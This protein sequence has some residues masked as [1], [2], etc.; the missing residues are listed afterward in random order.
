M[1][2]LEL[3]TDR[4]RIALVRLS[5][6]G[7]V[8]RVLPV[9]ASLRSR[10][11]EC[12]LT[13][14]VEPGP[15]G[16]LAGHPEVDRFLLFR[17]GLGPAAHAELWWKGRGLEFDLVLDLHRY[18]KAG[19]V[20]GLLDA[21]VKLGFD[22]DR[23]ADL[24]WWFTT[25]RIPPNPRRHVQEEYFEFLD[26]LGVPVVREWPLPVTPGERRRQRAEMEGLG[27]VL[28][29]QLGSSTEAKD[30]PVERWA[31]ALEAVRRDLGLRPVLI[32]GRSGREDRA[33]RRLKELTGVRVRDVREQDLRRLLWTAAGC[34]VVA[35]P[36]SGPVHVAA[37]AGVPVVG[38]Y[39]YTDPARHG[40]RGPVEGLDE[41]VVDRFGPRPGGRPTDETRPGRMELVT[42]EEVVGK[43]ERARDL[44]RELGRTG[45]HGR[46][47]DAGGDRR[48]GDGRDGE[49]G[50]GGGRD[51]AGRPG[52]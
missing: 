14:V 13:W 41:L 51:A 35:G 21:P 7:D 42:V 27:E 30:W 39:G 19:L 18:F 45:G 23:S 36:D 31:R 33:A 2:S 50:A 16:L 8:V 1:A 38:L 9:V 37:A 15:H 43:I 29:V 32:G 17:R 5:S 6:L 3:Q 46:A 34:T 24:N 25:H 10:W 22:R 11:P 49:S 48:E 28:G 26:H 4:P 44:A 40:P 12:E 52:P 47:S 20:T